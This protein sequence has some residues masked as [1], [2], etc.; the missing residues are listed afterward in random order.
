MVQL[1]DKRPTPS[2][3]PINMRFRFRKRG[4]LMYI[5]H[6]DLVRTFGKIVVRS[7]LPLWFT[8]GFNPKPKM[9]FSPPLSLGVESET[10][11]L[12]LRLTEHID[13]ALALAAMNRSVTDELRMLEAYE[14]EEKL[15][16][17]RYLSYDVRIRTAG[18]DD[19]L[20]AACERTLLSDDIPYLKRGK[21]GERLVN[22]RTGIEELSVTYEDGELRMRALL[23]A[24]PASF[25]NPQRLVDVLKDKHGILSSP[26][27]LSE[28]VHILRL[29]AYRA[30]KTLFR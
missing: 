23:D 24:D 4:R 6:L 18:A 26:D 5:S 10:E 25:L 9:V 22:L 27:I 3:V 17:I 19:V 1:T 30:D 14:P 15:G 8:E 28:D 12:D 20:A 2:N 16:A 11:F 21:A 29:Q 7:R 13:P